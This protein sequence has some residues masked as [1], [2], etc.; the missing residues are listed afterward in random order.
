M[1]TLQKI[2]L[3]LSKLISISSFCEIFFGSRFWY[4]FLTSSMLIWLNL[5]I[6][7]LLSA[8][9]NLILKRSHN[10]SIIF[11]IGSCSNESGHLYPW[12]GIFKIGIFI[13]YSLNC[14]QPALTILLFMNSTN[15]VK[16]D[17]L[18]VN[19]VILKIP[20]LLTKQ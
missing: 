5:K 19:L 7:K 2:M 4:I 1:L 16:V 17:S 3:F 8:F 13:K 12:L 14:K 20:I 11:S 15:F 6:W 18:K 10:I 9:I